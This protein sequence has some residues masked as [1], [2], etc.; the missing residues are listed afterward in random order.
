M[1]SQAT[2]L[3]K[4]GAAC[5]LAALL[6]CDFSHSIIFRNRA[7]RDISDGARSPNFPCHAL[8]PDIVY[9]H[10]H[11]KVRHDQ[12]TLPQ[13]LKIA[14]SLPIPGPQGWL[15]WPGLAW[16]CRATARLP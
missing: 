5:R 6:P 3:G 1:A 4:G 9:A 12:P 13:V 15:V 7:R 14:T 11:T 8:V 16:P 10:G 2:G